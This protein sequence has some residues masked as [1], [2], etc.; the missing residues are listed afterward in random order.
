MAVATKKRDAGA[1]LAAHMRAV[2]TCE[3]CVHYVSVAGT[4]MPEGVC[5]RHPP[6]PFLLT[7]GNVRSVFPPVRG[8]WSCGQFEAQPSTRDG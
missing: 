8:D 4:E 6:L 3:T 2:T 5:R 1:T 7:N